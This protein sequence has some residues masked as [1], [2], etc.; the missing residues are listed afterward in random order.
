MAEKI[1]TTTDLCNILQISKG[2]VFK[3][4]HSGELEFFRIGRSI[5]ITET[6]LNN[7]IIARSSK[8]EGSKHD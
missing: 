3:L 6:A 5:R 8:K 1:Y 4:L 2:Q 7:Y